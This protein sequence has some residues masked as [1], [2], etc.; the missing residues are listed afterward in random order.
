M[1]I[2]VEYTIFVY[3]LILLVIAYDSSSIIVFDN[4]SHIIM[5][6]KYNSSSTYFIIS[7]YTPIY[8]L[9]KFFHIYVV[10]PISKIK[11]FLHQ[12][13]GDPLP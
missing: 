4:K 12:A 2:L 1:I 7:L 3:V 13:A 11:V 10:V 9:D 5:L 6:T 8:S